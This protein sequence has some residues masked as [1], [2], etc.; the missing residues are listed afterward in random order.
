MLN[1]DIEQLFYIRA[2]LEGPPRLSRV[3]A[4]SAAAPQSPTPASTPLWDN[5]P[6]SLRRLSDSSSAEKK[7]TGIP[8]RE[9]RF[10]GGGGWIRTTEAKRNRFTVCPLWP[11]G[12]SSIFSWSW[13]TDSN[14]RPADY[15]SAALPAELH[16]HVRLS[17]SKRY[18]NKER[19]G[20][21]VE[22]KKNFMPPLRDSQAEGPAWFCPKCGGEQYRFD[23]GGSRRG[24]R[25]CA[26]CLRFLETEEGLP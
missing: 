22:I 21:Q 2:G 23:R 17:N 19:L 26:L 18:Y 16:Q 25:L 8:L 3:P 15:K 12:N 6:V 7:K 13:W 20:C 10:S 14:P 1:S 9:H 11:L 24:R 4:N 5:A